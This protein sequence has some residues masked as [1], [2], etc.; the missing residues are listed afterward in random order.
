MAIFAVIQQP[1]PGGD[2]LP[3]TI[4]KEFPDA[5]YVISQGVW[6]VAGSGT[7]QDTTLKL[8]IV[9]ATDAGSAV[10]IEAASYYGRANPAIWSWIKSN[11]EAKGNG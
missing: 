11:W 10:V 7:A 8:G 5:N 6:L 4:A 1:G 9:P 3:A 2:K